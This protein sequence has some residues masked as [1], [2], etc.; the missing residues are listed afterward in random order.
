MT[1]LGSPL[2]VMIQ[3]WLKQSEIAQHGLVQIP[4]CEVSTMLNAKHDLVLILHCVDSTTLIAKLDLEL[5]HK[6]VKDTKQMR[7]P[8]SSKWTHIRAWPR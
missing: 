4:P 8:A 2:V 5:T 7:L 3:T 1:L 6:H